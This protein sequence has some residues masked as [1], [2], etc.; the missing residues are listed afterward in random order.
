[1]GF[2]RF[3]RFFKIFQIP[4]NTHFGH[5]LDTTTYQVKVWADIPFLSGS[6]LF[7]LSYETTTI[8][9]KLTYLNYKPL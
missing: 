5:S 2:K 8:L 4:Y 7:Q 6:L 1:M 9:N 3:A